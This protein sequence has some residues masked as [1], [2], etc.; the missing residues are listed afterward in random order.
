[1]YIYYLTVLELRI[2]K[3]QVLKNLDWLRISKIIR[4][5][6]FVLFCCLRLLSSNF[7]FPITF[8]YR[9]QKETRMYFQHFAWK[10][11]Q[12]STLSYGP[13]RP[14]STNLWDTCQPSFMPLYTKQEID[15]LETLLKNTNATPY[16]L[17]QNFL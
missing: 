10:S 11:P 2:L 12:L 17:N 3:S 14:L 9:Q 16:L 7:L 1:M 6:V 15:H 8:Y 5:W 13:E 4:C